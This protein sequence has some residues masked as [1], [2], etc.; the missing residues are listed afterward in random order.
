MNAETLAKST[1]PFY[2]SRTTRKV[3]LG[4]S[5]FKQNA[6]QTGGSLYITSELNKGTVVK[7][8]F[9]LKHID[10]TELGDMAGVVTLLVAANPNIDSVYIHTVNEVQYKFDTIEVKQM[11]DGMPINTPDIIRSMKEMIQENLNEINASK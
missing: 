7:A 11:L 4:L 3:G 10:R 2:T 9:G 8:C 5:M 1:D 6:E